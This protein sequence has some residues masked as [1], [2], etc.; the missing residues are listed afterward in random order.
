MK[1]EM[2]DLMTPLKIHVATITRVV[3]RLLRI[4]FDGWEPEYDQWIDAESPDIYPIG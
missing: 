4:S 2:A 1:V 3:G